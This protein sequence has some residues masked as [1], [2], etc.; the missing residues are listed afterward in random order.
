MA[1]ISGVF[2]GSG[3][4]DT[5]LGLPRAATA[6]LAP[7]AA[8]VAILGAPCA[9]PYAGTGLYAAGAPGAIRAAAAVYAGA[10]AHQ[11]VRLDDA[12]GGHS[13]VDLGFG[14]RVGSLGENEPAD[15]DRQHRRVA[16][17]ELAFQEGEEG[18]EARVEQR[19]VE[20]ETVPCRCRIGGEQAHV[21]T[22]VVDER[23][24]VGAAEH[25]TVRQ[26]ERRRHLVKTRGRYLGGTIG[27]RFGGGCDGRRRGLGDGRLH[28]RHE[29]VVRQPH[30]AFDHER[31]RRDLA[32]AH[33]ALVSLFENERRVDVEVAD[34]HGDAGIKEA[35]R[36]QQHLGEAGGG[37]H[38]RVLHLVIGEERQAPRVMADVP[39]RFV[40]AEALAQQHVLPPREEAHPL[41]G[42][43]V[44]VVLVLPGIVRQQRG[45]R[46][47]RTE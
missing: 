33:L 36:A 45:R 15:P 22:R 13:N 35:R 12:L 19:R 6:A 42:L 25:R 26:A 43:G 28:M 30:P 39:D 38:H 32:G 8:D 24:S 1:D 7:G 20:R 4:V 37:E 16:T 27:Q 9:T 5:F 10:V 21:R 11:E 23:D 31:L 44:A 40:T 18:V 29:A 14:R 47:P 46:G 17:G 34:L 41:R 2:G 3:S